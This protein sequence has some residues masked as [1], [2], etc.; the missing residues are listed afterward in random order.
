MEKKKKKERRTEKVRGKKRGKREKEKKSSSEGRMTSKRKPSLL[1][2]LK[3][4]SHNAATKKLLNPGFNK[5]KLCSLTCGG[6]FKKASNGSNP[7]ESLGQVKTCLTKV[8]TSRLKLY[9]GLDPL[10][11]RDPTPEKVLTKSRHV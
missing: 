10:I 8:L 2:F 3:K 7:E 6:N 9:S 11:F 1:T 4:G 5:N